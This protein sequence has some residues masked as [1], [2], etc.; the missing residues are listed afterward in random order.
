LGPPYRRRE[1]RTSASRRRTL[2][3]EERR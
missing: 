1:N 3:V 2:P